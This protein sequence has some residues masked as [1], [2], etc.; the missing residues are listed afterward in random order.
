MPRDQQPEAYVNAARRIRRA[1]SIADVASAALLAVTADAPLGP[2]DVR[3]RAIARRAVEALLKRLAF[4]L[5]QRAVASPEMAHELRAESRRR[6]ARVLNSVPGCCHAEEIA[7]LAVTRLVPTGGAEDLLAATRDAISEG[8]RANVALC[9]L[10][11]RLLVSSAA[12]EFARA[13][14][15][16]DAELEA[17]LHEAAAPVRRAC[18]AADVCEVGELRFTRLL[19]D[20][21]LAIIAHLDGS[22]GLAPVIRLRLQETGAGDK[23]WHSAP[24]AHA[25]DAYPARLLRRFVS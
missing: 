1:G 24:H 22:A 23:P 9:C 10:A 6:L 17:L 14:G 7:E 13:H 12:H 3:R 21:G 25:T 2:A 20:R 15:L 16:Q 8:E 19:P 4:S 18:E 5:A 11:G